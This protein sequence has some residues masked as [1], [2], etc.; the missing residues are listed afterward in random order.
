MTATLEKRDNPARRAAVERAHVEDATAASV[1]EKLDG[2]VKAGEGMR[3]GR[4]LLITGPAG[5]GKSHLIKRFR[6]RHDLAPYE[7][8]TGE[9][10][11]RPIIFVNAPSPCTL[12]ALG[13]EILTELTGVPPRT[14]MLSHAVWSRVRRQMVANR[15]K[16]LVIDEIHHVLQRKNDAEAESLAETFKNV[17]Q[18][19]EWPINLVLGGM[20]LT[21]KFTREHPQFGRRI[22]IV[23]IEPV[24]DNDDGYLKIGRYLDNLVPRLEFAGI[25]SLSEADMPLRF[26]RATGGYLGSVANVVKTAAHI[27]LDQE[28][29]VIDREDLAEAVKAIFK[30]SSHENP[31]LVENPDDLRRTAHD[32]ASRRTKLAGS[33]H[34]S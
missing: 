10:T 32:S 6:T 34:A 1:Q 9:G 28:G 14:N 33:A 31:F 3:D 26:Q 30:M 19:P 22:D 4:G 18:N 12:K 11:A 2:L 16:F 23:S 7:M 21:N 20:P 24:P 5:S 15:T 13:Y 8:E 17:M 27:A 25:F 29:A